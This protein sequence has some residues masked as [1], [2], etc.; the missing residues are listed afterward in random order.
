[1]Y[2]TKGYLSSVTMWGLIAVAVPYIDQ[3]Y[4]YLAT[5][6]EGTLPKGAAVAVQGLGLLLAM[7]GRRNATQKLRVGGKP[8]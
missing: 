6:P 7:L 2:N 4:Q 1:M 5:L 8:A 3:A